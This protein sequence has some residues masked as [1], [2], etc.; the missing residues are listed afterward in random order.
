MVILVGIFKG[1]FIPILDIELARFRSFNRD[2]FIVRYRDIPANVNEQITLDCSLPK[3]E[4]YEWQLSAKS[5]SPYAGNV[6]LGLP[7]NRDI[8]KPWSITVRYQN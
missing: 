2:V 8:F 1:N 5:G 7:L 6:Q 3:A 4:T